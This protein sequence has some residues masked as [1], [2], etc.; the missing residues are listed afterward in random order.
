MAFRLDNELSAVNTIL[1]AIGQAPITQL[2]FDNPEISFIHNLLGEC[3]VDVQSE[4]W[5]FNTEY[6]VFFTPDNNN[7]IIIPANTLRV[8]LSQDRMVK[9]NGFN[10]TIRQGKLYDLTAHTFDFDDWRGSRLNTDYTWTANQRGVNLDVVTLIQF[11]HL[12][13]VVQ[14]YVTYR[15]A[16]RAATQLVSNAD[17]MKMITQQTNYLRTSL[18]AFEAEQSE[19]NF[20]GYP[21]MQ[22]YHTFNSFLPLMR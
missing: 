9:H 19:A 6:S 13:A 8:S 22:T 10:V 1:G 21:D 5:Q 2:E 18:I 7:E 16:E 4:G 20:M 17:L 12:P 11:E 3:N 15:A 14:R